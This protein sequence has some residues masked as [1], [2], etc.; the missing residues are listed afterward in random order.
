VTHVSTSD[1]GG[2]SLTSIRI[3]AF[4]LYWLGVITSTR[5]LA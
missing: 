2:V 3:G 4:Q 1:A 5:P